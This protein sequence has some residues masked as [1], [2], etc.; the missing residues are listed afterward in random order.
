MPAQQKHQHQQVC[1]S[2]R[3]LVCAWHLHNGSLAVCRLAGLQPMFS[4]IPAACSLAC[5]GPKQ[6]LP[7]WGA[8]QLRSQWYQ[9]SSAKPDVFVHPIPAGGLATASAGQAGSSRTMTGLQGQQQWQGVNG[10]S[11]PN[12]ALRELAASSQSVAPSMVPSL[13]DAMA[14]DARALHAQAAQARSL[15]AKGAGASAC[16]DGGSARGARPNLT[17]GLTQAVNEG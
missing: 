9:L 14:Y 13:V 12:A 8:P 7:M 16:T 4:A 5:A 3:S 10:V 11:D 17:S 2:V 6:V 15:V 1:V